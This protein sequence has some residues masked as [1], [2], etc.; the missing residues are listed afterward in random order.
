MHHFVFLAMPTAPP[1]CVSPCKLASTI[2]HPNR[3]PSPPLS[4]KVPTCGADTRPGIATEDEVR[5]AFP[6]PACLPR[7]VMREPAESLRCAY[8]MLRQ[9]NACCLLLTALHC[10]P[11]PA[12]RPSPPS[13]ALPRPICLHFPHRRADHTKLHQAS[14]LW[15]KK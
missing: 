15:Q 4:R 5:M 12:P 3:P 13:P 2:C 11:A 10:I 1:T 6:F 9:C 7:P 14:Q 8:A